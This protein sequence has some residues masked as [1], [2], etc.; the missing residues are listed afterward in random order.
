MKSDAV[1]YVHLA[2]LSGPM[3]ASASC[4]IASLE[5]VS[6]PSAAAYIAAVDLVL[7]SKIEN[8]FYSF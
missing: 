7:E 5:V 3:S 6:V 2:F 1:S 4:A 8:I